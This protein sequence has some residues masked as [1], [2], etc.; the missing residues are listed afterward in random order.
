MNTTNEADVK[1]SLKGTLHRDLAAFRSER[2]RTEHG[3]NVETKCVT[4]FEGWESPA[5]VPT[6]DQCRLL[7]HLRAQPKASVSALGRNVY[8]YLR[9][10]QADVNALEATVQV[11]RSPG[12]VGGT[13][14]RAKQ[15]R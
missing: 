15:P 14:V 8:C 3:G 11:M 13:A 2:E 6:G 12:S 1:P 9:R 7:K 10:V 4:A 5:S